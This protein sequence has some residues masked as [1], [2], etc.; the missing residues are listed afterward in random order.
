MGSMSD[1]SREMEGCV[2]PG[3]ASTRNLLDARVAVLVGIGGVCLSALV[4]LLIIDWLAGLHNAALSVGLACS[5]MVLGL[6]AGARL[7]RGHDVTRAR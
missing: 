5:T 6:L 7:L 2:R 1:G 3:T 4:V